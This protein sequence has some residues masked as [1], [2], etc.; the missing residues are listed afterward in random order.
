MYKMQLIIRYR[1]SIMINTV[2]LNPVV[3]ILGGALIIVWSFYFWCIFGKCI[4]YAC[5]QLVQVWHIFFYI[6]N[7][8]KEVKAV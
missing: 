8:Y 2:V 3:V 5:I 6:T 4:K 1:H 7:L